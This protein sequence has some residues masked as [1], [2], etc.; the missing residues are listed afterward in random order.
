MKIK[1]E[2]IGKEVVDVNAM[3]VGKV[4]D[5]EANFESKTI[6]SFLVGG[7][8][9]LESLGS[10]KNDIVIPL[11]MVVAIGDKVIVKSENQPSD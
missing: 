2:M 4:K 9:I 6:E 11:R 10:S 1:E 5:V 7:G 8:G 3:I